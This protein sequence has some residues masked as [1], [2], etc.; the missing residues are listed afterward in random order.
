M[1]T[2]LAFDWRE[3]NEAVHV[4]KHSV[5]F[6][7]AIGVFSDD[8]R[9]EDE[10]RRQPHDPPRFNTVGLVDGLCINVTFAVRGDVAVIISA[11]QASRKERRRYGTK[12]IG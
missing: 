3:D 5:P 6:A 8:D 2:P 9:I 4:A 1:Q 7:F 11:R 10:D 12:D